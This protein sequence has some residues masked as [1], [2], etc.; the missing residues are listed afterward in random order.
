MLSGFVALVGD[1]FRWES[2]FIGWK[3]GLLQGDPGIQ[4]FAVN[5]PVKDPLANLIV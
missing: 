2:I 4:Y 5:F 1:F 3:R